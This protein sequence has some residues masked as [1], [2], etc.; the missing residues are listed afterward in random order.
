MTNKLD[1][2]KFESLKSYSGSLYV[3]NESF[4]LKKKRKKNIRR[5]FEGNSSESLKYSSLGSLNM[6]SGKL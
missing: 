6:L 2:G 5:S 4:S 1:L 3:R